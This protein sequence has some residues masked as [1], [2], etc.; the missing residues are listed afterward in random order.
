MLITS[1]LKNAFD[2]LV[3]YDRKLFIVEIK[4]GNKP[5]SQRR[6]TEGEIKCRDAFESVGVTYHIIESV[7]AAISMIKG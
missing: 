1:S 2:I 6:L 4:D 5:P 3:G 7:E